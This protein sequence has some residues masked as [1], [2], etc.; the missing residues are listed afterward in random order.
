[1]TGSRGVGKYGFVREHGLLSAEQQEAGRRT[2]DLVDKHGLRTVRMIWVDQHGAARCKFMSVPDYLASLESG[3]DFSGAL[4][5]MDSANNVFTPVF[6]EGGGLDIPELTGFPDMVL[7]PDPITFRVLPWANR[8][9]WVICDAY[10]TNGKPVPLDT[11]QLLR[12]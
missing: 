2:A 9:A 5:N 11:R 6:A 12:Q 1:M 7:V 10:F 3:I 8:T 4:L